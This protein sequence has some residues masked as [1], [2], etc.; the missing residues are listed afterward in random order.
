MADYNYPSPSE[1]ARIEREA[2][3][4]RAEAI[5]DG[6]AAMVRAISGGFR[7]L[8]NVFATRKHA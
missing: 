5:R 8:G 2:E 7:R 1:I 3:Q 6:F 4:M